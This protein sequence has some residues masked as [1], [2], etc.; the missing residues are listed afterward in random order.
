MQKSKGCK[1]E[2]LQW[3]L[4][5]T[6]NCEHVSHLSIHLPIIHIPTH[7][8]IY[9]FTHLSIHLPPPPTSH[10]SIH[11]SIYLLIHPPTHPSIHLAITPTFL[12]HL[13]CN[14]VSSF[15][16]CDALT[17]ARMHIGTQLFR[18]SWCCA[19]SPCSQR[20][21]F[22]IQSSQSRAYIPNHLLYWFLTF[23]ATIHLPYYPKAGCQETRKSPYT[24][25]P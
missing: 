19:E 20:C 18:T 7:P 5:T 2:T 21:A 15:C 13:L 1:I 22:Q 6:W 12:K 24:Q 3:S 25:S 8:H 14:Q 11:S 16:K 17:S 10:P 9:L 4:L 23:G